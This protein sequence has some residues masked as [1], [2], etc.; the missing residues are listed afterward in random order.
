VMGFDEAGV[1]INNTHMMEVCLLHHVGT[2]L[3]FRDL[4]LRKSDHTWH[5]LP[6]P[7]ERPTYPRAFGKFIAATEYANPSQ[8]NPSS[9]GKE[10]WKRGT[11]EMNPGS[12]M[13]EQGGHVLPGR[14][15]IY[16]I[17]TEK[18]FTIETKQGDSEVLLIDGG[19]VYWR[20]AAKLYSAPITESGIGQPT[21]LANDDVVLDTHY[22]FVKR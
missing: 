3:T 10:E 20:A 2:T 19:V 15:H 13:L 4:V 7:T 9:A 18:T 1:G 5:T 16:N 11:R 17:D 14:L 12:W 22:A 21:L 8:R 6:F